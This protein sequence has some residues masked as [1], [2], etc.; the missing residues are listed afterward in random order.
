MKRKLEGG[1]SL[2][3]ILK[4]KVQENVDVGWLLV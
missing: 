4:E 3:W 1:M 2:P